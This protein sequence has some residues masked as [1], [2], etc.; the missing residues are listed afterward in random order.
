LKEQFPDFNPEILQV[1]P[2][3]TN[4]GAT[5]AIGAEVDALLKIPDLTFLKRSARSQCLDGGELFGRENIDIWN[6]FKSDSNRATGGAHCTM[7]AGVQFHQL[8]H[9]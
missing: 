8:N 7:G 1:D 5:V 9:G 3:G 4:H 6:S 2:Y